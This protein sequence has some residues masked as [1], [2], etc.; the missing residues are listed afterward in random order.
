MKRP[1]GTITRG[2]TH[3]NRLRRVDAWLAWRYQH[4]LTHTG[5]PL[6]VDLGYGHTPITTLEMA[7]RLLSLNP[8]L[9]VVGLEIDAERVSA[10]HRY[11]TEQVQF[12]LGGFEV[13]TC[14]NPILIRAFNV[15]RQYAESEVRQHWHTMQSRLATQGRIIEGTCD[16]PG[17]LASWVELDVQQPLSLTLAA[18]LPRLK[19]ISDIAPRL[20]KVLIHHNIA[21]HPI[22]RFFRDADAAWA[23]HSG[24]RIFG[25]RQRWAATLRSLR[26]TWP[27]LTPPS[28]DRH[29]EMTIAWSALTD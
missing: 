15:L 8:G 26:G 5:S 18:S 13:P 20:P 16:E 6:I 9:R 2:T 10:A 17:R 3:P 25:A 14:E 4:L 28:R 23:S 29:G 27:V 19:Q 12:A 22:H 7:E 24:L 21:G 1:I 11:A